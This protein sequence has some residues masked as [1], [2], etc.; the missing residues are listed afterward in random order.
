MVFFHHMCYTKLD[1]AGWSDGIVRSL[2]TVTSFWDTGVD[3]FF[4]LSG[5]LITSILL[6]DRQNPDYYKDFYWKRALR[7]LPLYALC[8]IGILIFIPGSHRFV[9]LCVLFLANFA[10]LFHVPSIG[11]FWSLAIEEQFY[12]LWPT[13]VRRRSIATLRH[14]AFAIVCAVIVLRFVFAFSGHHNYWHT[15]LRCDG[16][17][18]GALLA[19]MLERAQSIGQGLASKRGVLLAMLAAGAV[20]LAVSF[21][22]PQDNKH[23]AFHAA[24]EAAS[25]TFLCG[26]FVGIAI[27]YT[28]RPWLGILRSRILTFFGL[29]SYAL[30][31]VHLFVRDIY[32]NW[33]GPLQPGDTAGYFIRL[34]V[35]LG[36]T[37][38]IT[39]ITRYTIE[40]PVMSLRKYV[41]HKSTKPAVAEAL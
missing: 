32:D 6:R 40:L 12:V 2:Y 13:V 8:A 21:L 29:I 5:F 15:Y 11:P 10:N 33:R 19:C 9:L 23:I 41:L 3:V 30:Y 27:A 16:L 22:I 31:M 35:V 37:I 20:L 25:I 39:L 36:V 34:A 26:S 7:V 14:W 1:I 28:G 17:A 38:V 4:V 24:T 18:L